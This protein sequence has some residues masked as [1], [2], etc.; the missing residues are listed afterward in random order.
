MIA[1]IPKMTSPT[2]DMDYETLKT[3]YDSDLNVIK[4]LVET[5]N[6]EPTPLDCVEEMV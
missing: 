5:S 2:I 3:Y 4:E 1:Q 6:D